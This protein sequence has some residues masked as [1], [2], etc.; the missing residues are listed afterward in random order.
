MGYYLGWGEIPT[1][2]IIFD[3]KPLPEPSKHP[4]K[5]PVSETFQIVPMEVAASCLPGRRYL[6][7]ALS[8][9]SSTVF[10]FFVWISLFHTDLKRKKFPVGKS[11]F[12]AGGRF[13]AWVV[14]SKMCL[15]ILHPEILGGL[16][17]PRLN[18]SQENSS[19]CFR[20]AA[21]LSSNFEFS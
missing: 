10:E 15:L 5:Y 20:W 4:S 9:S 16:E 11:A 18:L 7:I 13:W 21:I 1:D 17:N 2:P 6:G 14:I 8:F 19:F 12:V 3:Q